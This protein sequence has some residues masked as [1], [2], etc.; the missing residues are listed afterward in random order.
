MIIKGEIKWLKVQVEQRLGVMP[1]TKTQLLLHPQDLQTLNGKLKRYG[2]KIFNF[3]IFILKYKLF[4]KALR[5]RELEE[6][7][8]RAAQMEKTMRWWSDCTANWRE[9]W[10]K[11]RSERNKARDESKQL[12]TKLDCALKDVNSYKRDKQEL[13]LQ[14]EQ[15][16]KEIEKI[17]L[18]LL[19]HAGQFDSQIFEALG[20]DP[21]KDFTFS[22]NHDSPIRNCVNLSNGVIGTN[23]SIEFDSTA[24]SL[25]DLDKDSCIEE[26]ILQG[27]VPRH[28][29][30][31]IEPL[32]N[33]NDIDLDGVTNG[34]DSKSD[35]TS[36]KDDIDEDYVIQKMSML[37]LRLEEATKTLQIERE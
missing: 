17:H 24:T 1:E 30:D 4:L 34:F 33:K 6:A 12:R 16:K 31:H 3:E 35:R 32:D 7:R 5:Q 18:L 19:K 15:L 20:E 23:A 22:Q 9:K 26:Y 14:N 13:E 10:S 27:A 2:Y 36:R 25:I 21:L 37:Q 29:S 11:V 8:A 28:S